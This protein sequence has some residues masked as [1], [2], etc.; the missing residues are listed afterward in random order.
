M[1][2]CVVCITLGMQKNLS[3]LCHLHFLVGFLFMYVYVYFNNIK[4]SRDRITL[5]ENPSRTP[6]SLLKSVGDI[7]SLPYYHPISYFIF[8]MYKFV[9]KEEGRI[10]YI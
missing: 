6:R 8:V 5:D 9:V 4:V 7:L 2:I 10:Y 3:Q 1:S